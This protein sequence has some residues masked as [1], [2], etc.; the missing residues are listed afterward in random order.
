M[1]HEPVFL[2]HEPFPVVHCRCFSD[3]LN[4]SESISNRCLFRPW[5]GLWNRRRGTKVQSSCQGAPWSAPKLL[6]VPLD[7]PDCNPAITALKFA[8]STKITDYKFSWFWRQSKF[9]GLPFN[10]PSLLLL[11]K[12]SKE[13]VELR[14]I[15]SI[16]DLICLSSY[17]LNA[18][19]WILCHG[20]KKSI[21]AIFLWMNYVFVF[22]C[23]KIVSL[24]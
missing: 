8:W 17:A 18:A 23:I 15:Q 3:C 7:H 4:F 20:L 21:E 10:D 13:A 16:A 24:D 6:V 22:T 14:H 12:Q 11:I 19:E 2:A 5:N 9:S 1:A